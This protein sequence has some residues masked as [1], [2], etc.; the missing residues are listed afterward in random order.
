MAE[1]ITDCEAL[2]CGGMGKGAYESLNERGIRPVIT[3]ILDID[4]VLTSYIGGQIID[5]TE[6]LH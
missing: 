3:D 4:E 1:A 5:H 6:K 2:L